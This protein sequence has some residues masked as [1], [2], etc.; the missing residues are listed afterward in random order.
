[1]RNFAR[2]AALALVLAT[3]ACT[4][5]DDVMA[6]VFG[7]SMRDQATF[8]PYEDPL[9]PAEGAVSFASG[10]FPAQFGDVNLG[11]PEASDYLVPA[12]TQAQTANPNHPVWSEFEN[13]LEASDEVLAKG[14]EQYQRYCAVCHGDAGVGAEAWILEKWPALVAYNLAGETVQAYPDTYIYGMIRRGRGMMPQ[15]G[16]QITNFDRWAIVNY[17]RS[18]QTTYNAQNADGDED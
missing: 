13:P 12:F 3:G 8:D 18:L 5:M 11:Q 16:H 2:L 1:M 4:P 9:L 10:N 7:R 6:A 17:V 15:Y 14:Q